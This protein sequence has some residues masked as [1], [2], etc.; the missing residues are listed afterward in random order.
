MSFLPTTSRSLRTT[1]ASCSRYF[2]TSTCALE[3]V[4]RPSGSAPAPYSQE[5]GQSH[6]DLMEELGRSLKETRPSEAFG[7]SEGFSSTPSTPM[8]TFRSGQLYSPIDLHKSKLFPTARRGAKPPL[9]GPPAPLA[10]R[11]DPFYILDVNPINEAINHK[12]VS[13]YI[14]QMG[15]IKTR[16]ETSL[17][18]KNQRKVGK[19]VR[20]ARAMGLISRWDNTLSRDLTS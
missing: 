2:S 13:A 14:T 16:A 7:G 3:R 5:D 20:R 17:T 9:L 10:K 15:K 19:M 1:H 11:S 4:T 12:L 8:E 6:R 18:W